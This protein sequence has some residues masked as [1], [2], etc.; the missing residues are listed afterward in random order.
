MCSP[1]APGCVSTN[2]TYMFQV[3]TKGKTCTHVL[4]CAIVTPQPASQFREGSDAVT[5]P[6]F[7]T[8]SLRLGGFWCCYVSRDFRSR[9]TVHEGSGAVTRPSAL[10][11]IS[12]RRRAL[13]QTHVHGACTT[14]ASE[15]GSDVDTCPMAL[16]G[17]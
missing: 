17:P 16:Y 7:Q 1:L 6:M 14:S 4:P 12:P 15:V 13:T 9:L 8:S 11:P 10:G 3:K 5:C 2:P